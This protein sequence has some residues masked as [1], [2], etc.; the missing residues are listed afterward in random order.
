MDEVLA[1]PNG[2]AYTGWHKAEKGGHAPMPRAVFEPI[3][4]V[5]AVRRYARPLRPVLDE[6]KLKNN[7]FIIRG[8]LNIYAANVRTEKPRRRYTWEI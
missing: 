4:R 8:E 5:Q 2:C 3:T 7:I 6:S 1:L